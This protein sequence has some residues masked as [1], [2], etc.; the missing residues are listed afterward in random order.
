MRNNI[1]LY[2]VVVLLFFFRSLDDTDIKK[3]MIVFIL[4]A[5]FRFDA[6]ARK[7]NSW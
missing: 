6:L 5:S 7:Y 3:Y 2:F 4:Y 1:P